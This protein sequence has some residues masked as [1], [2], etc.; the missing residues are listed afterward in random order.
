M[1]DSIRLRMQE[2]I[3]RKQQEIVQTLEKIEALE[4]ETKFFQD[5][6][7]REGAEGGG[8]SAVIQN[9]TVIEKGGVMVSIVNSKLPPAAVERMRADHKVLDM[10]AE[11]QKKKAA[12]GSTEQLSL[13]FDVCG[14]SLIMHPSNPHA[15]TVHL[16]YRYFEIKHP[17]TN[18][19][20]TWWFGGGADMTPHYLYEEDAELFH[21]ELKKACDLIGPSYYPRFKKWCDEYF[22]VK[23]RKEGRGIGGIFFDDMG[24]EETSE[25][26][27]SAED[28]LKFIEACFD[29]F[30]NSYPTI[31]KRRYKT[32][33]DQE[34]KRWQLIRRGR[35]VEFNLLYDRGTHFGLLTPNARIESI[36]VS[37]PQNVSWEYMHEP[38]QDSWE[39]KTLQVLKNP[40]EWVKE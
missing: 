38:T 12:E 6:W 16:N 34:Q 2:L 31:L 27:R 7:S 1:A 3:Q 22:F 23:H 30:L 24:P 28:W 25:K 21:T 39:D 32:E 40:R 15:P 33:F 17:D 26:G 19:I 36:L 29:A 5:K 20:L 18:E 8:I 35:Y 13:P 10:L 9:G 11:E 4:S 37:L 14:L